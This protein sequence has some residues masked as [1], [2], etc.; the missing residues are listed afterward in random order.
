MLFRLIRSRDTLQRA[1]KAALAVHR[2][3]ILRELLANHGETAFAAALTESSGR[4]V[5]DAL[6]ML[7]QQEFAS[8]FRHLSNDAQARHA[9]DFER[10]RTHLPRGAAVSRPPLQG[11]LVWT[12]HA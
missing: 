9:S 3:T 1:I 8:V 5:A 2:P 12:R 7:A 6:S 4:V 11:V 10:E